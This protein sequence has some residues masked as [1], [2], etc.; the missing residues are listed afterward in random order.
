MTVVAPIT[1]SGFFSI[2]FS[3]FFSKP[4]AQM[5]VGDIASSVVKNE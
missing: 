5:E 2:T 1:F 3:G 4:N